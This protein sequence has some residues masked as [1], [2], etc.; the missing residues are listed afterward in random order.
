MSNQFWMK[1]MEKKDGRVNKTL[2]FS[3][4]RVNFVKRSHYSI[5]VVFDSV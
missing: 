4:V 5:V 2:V 1:E 3:H